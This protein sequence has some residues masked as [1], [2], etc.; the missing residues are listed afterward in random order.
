MH[1]TLSVRRCCFHLRSRRS[2]P[3]RTGLGGAPHTWVVRSPLCRDG[4]G[5][6]RHPVE[7]LHIGPLARAFLEDFGG[8]VDRVV[9]PDRAIPGVPSRD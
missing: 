4:R 1:L 6:P 7:R 5:Q 9:H 8:V 2:V 3:H